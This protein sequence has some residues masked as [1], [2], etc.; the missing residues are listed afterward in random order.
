MFPAISTR[1]TVTHAARLPGTPVRRHRLRRK[2]CP[3]H[4]LR[5][6]W[7][8]TRRQLI[9]VSTTTTFHPGTLLYARGRRQSTSRVMLRWTRR[10]RACG[11]RS[12]L[13][14][15]K[16]AMATAWRPLARRFWVSR[17]SRTMGSWFG[18]SPL[19]ASSSSSPPN[20]RWRQP[21]TRGASP[22]A[23]PGSSSVGGHG[24]SERRSSPSID[25]FH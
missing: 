3:T 22:S 4:L 7:R 25:G 1:A 17:G 16:C 18:G 15:P 11:L 24:L 23:P 14:R 10:K 21:Y 13:L 19:R 9:S 8:T 6:R 5:L 20:S 12:S 2:P